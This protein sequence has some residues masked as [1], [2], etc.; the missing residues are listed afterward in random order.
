M[1]RSRIL[2]VPMLAAVAVLAG[3]GGGDDDEGGGTSAKK[4]EPRLNQPPLAQVVQVAKRNKGLA[5]CKRVTEGLLD[6]TPDVESD[7]LEI[8]SILCDGK[9]VGDWRRYKDTVSRERFGAPIINDRPYFTNGNIVVTTG[10]AVLAD[11]NAEAWKTLPVELR[12]ACGCG[13]VEQ[14]R[15]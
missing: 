2:L 11:I 8:R 10:E 4:A 13:Q 9:I 14:P 12:A 7:P 3:C 6:N 1:R 5:K 15:Q